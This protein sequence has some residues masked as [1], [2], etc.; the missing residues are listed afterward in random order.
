MTTKCVGACVAGRGGAHAV[1]AFDD[2]ER[3]VA[4]DVR[5]R[6]PCRT[7]VR[8]ARPMEEQ[9]APVRVSARACAFMHVCARTRVC[10]CA[11]VCARVCTLCVRACVC[12]CACRCARMCQCLPS[13]VLLVQPRPAPRVTGA[14]RGTPTHVR[15]VELRELAHAVGT[16]T[17]AQGL[18]SPLPHRHRDWAHP[19]HIGTGTG[20]APAHADHCS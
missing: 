1:A 5:V 6:R 11:C 19:C 7:H 4:A 10:A 20:L 9:R 14:C 15:A 12:A 17:S 16:V 2:Q 18:G 8:C 13:H 3:L